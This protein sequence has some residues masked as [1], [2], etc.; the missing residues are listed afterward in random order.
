MGFPTYIQ[1]SN[2]SAQYWINAVEKSSD[3]SCL[4]TCG[5][6]PPHIF[7]LISK[8]HIIIL[9]LMASIGFLPIDLAKD[10]FGSFYFI[11]FIWPTIPRL[12]NIEKFNFEH[13]FFPFPG[14]PVVQI[15]IWCQIWNPRVRLPLEPKWPI[16][17]SNFYFFTFL[18]KI[19][20]IRR[21]WSPLSPY[22]PHGFSISQLSYLRAWDSNL[23]SK[24]QIYRLNIG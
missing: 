3:L 13:G 10:V 24:F 12:E 8:S 7:Q 14:Q 16:Q 1:I 11:H 2:L 15:K 6:Y 9:D 17:I 22:P 21:L 19:K 4:I 5:K 18:S 20:T 23:G